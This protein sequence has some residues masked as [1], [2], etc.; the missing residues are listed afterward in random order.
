[1]KEEDIRV[2]PLLEGAFYILH[3]P[4][5]YP[6]TTYDAAKEWVLTLLYS[7]SV[8]QWSCFCLVGYGTIPCV[9]ELYFVLQ[10]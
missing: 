4:D 2:S 8:S 1:M 6:E 7:H 10:P 9:L 5:D 3:H